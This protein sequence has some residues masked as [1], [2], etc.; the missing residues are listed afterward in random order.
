MTSGCQA[1]DPLYFP[2]T[3]SL[4]AH[5]PTGPECYKFSEPLHSPEFVMLYWCD[6]QIH[7]WHLTLQIG[8]SPSAGITPG[9]HHCIIRAEYMLAHGLYT[10]GRNEVKQQQANHSE[11]AG[12]GTLMVRFAHHH[13]GLSPFFHLRPSLLECMCVL[14]AYRS[15]SD[16]HWL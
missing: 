5:F 2:F 1:Q 15:W 7:V 13:F 12:R 10:S 4:G 16:A 6:F 8:S 14:S 11:G 3:Y 9:V